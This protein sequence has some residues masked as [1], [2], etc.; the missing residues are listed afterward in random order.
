MENPER[1]GGG[2]RWWD[3]GGEGASLGYTYWLSNN[4]LVVPTANLVSQRISSRKDSKTDCVWEAE[5]LGEARP[6]RSVAIASHF[7]AC[8]SPTFRRAGGRTPQ[9]AAREGA[10][11]RP[12][13]TPLSAIVLGVA[14]CPRIISLSF[15][16]RFA[17]GIWNSAFPSASAGSCTC[18]IIA[19]APLGRTSRSVANDPPRGTPLQPSQTFITATNITAASSL[20]TAVGVL[21]WHYVEQ[22]ESNKRAAHFFRSGENARHLYA[23]AKKERHFGITSSYLPTPPL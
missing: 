19:P 13:P 16:P 1:T 4:V 9:Q 14:L 23:L 17:L 5:S 20:C 21:P 6:R 11:L 22:R 15:V 12:P 8:L 10:P 18:A 2:G 3:Q 7:P